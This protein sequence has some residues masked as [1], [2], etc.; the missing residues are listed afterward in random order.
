MKTEINGEP[1]EF[2]ELRAEETAVDT[3]RQRCQLT[4]TK[5][6]CGSGVCGACTI[7]VNGTPMVSCLLPAHHLQ[8]QSVTTIEQYRDEQ[9]HPVQLIQPT[10]VIQLPLV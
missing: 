4:G 3:L 10:L 5:L 6:V 7:R 9:L 1:Y 2:E 8:G